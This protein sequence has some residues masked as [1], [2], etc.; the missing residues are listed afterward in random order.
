[1]NVCQ[2][3]VFSN[4]RSTDTNMT[5]LDPQISPSLIGERH[6]E[7]NNCTCSMLCT[8]I[9][10]CVQWPIESIVWLVEMWRSVSMEA[11]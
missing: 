9:E 4:P 2:M 5:H 7:E 1:M 10:V 3:P 6:T 8:I 11:C